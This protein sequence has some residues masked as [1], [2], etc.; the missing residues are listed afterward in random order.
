MTS[1]KYFHS[2]MPGAP[3]MSGIAGAMVAVLDACLVNGFGAGN[4]DSLTVTDGVATAIRSAGHPFSP[5][6]IVL[7]SGA[8]PAGLNGQFRVLTTTTTTY[9][10]AVTGV[11]NGPASGTIT[12]K[13][14]PAGWEKTYSTTNKAVYR[15]TNVEGTRC[16]LR[17]DDTVTLMS[18]V[19]GYSSMTDV[20]TGAGIFPSSSQMSGGA[21]WPKSNSS[22]SSS[23]VW[24]VI[25]DDRSFFIHVGF[26]GWSSYQGTCFFG[27]FTS[28]KQT[29]PYAC[30]LH[31]Y[32]SSG[33]VGN[34]DSTGD[35]GYSGGGNTWAPRGV[36]GL[37]GSQSLRRVAAIPLLSAMS[38]NSGDASNAHPAFPNPADNGLYL[39]EMLVGETSPVAS[40]RG[41]LPGL[42]YCFNGVG[43][44]VFPLHSK[45]TGVVG[46]PGRTLLTVPNYNGV[47]FFDITGPWR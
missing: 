1:V 30:A 37:G 20:D 27:D 10:F 26:G 12:H 46:M 28:K 6:Q 3:T 45:V 11:S 32:S 31:G 13:V 40:L 2:S 21:Y 36:S 18:R 34:S 9:T 24:T 7:I 22:D 38:A 41:T 23:R 17:V 47:N 44:A 43:N 8:T 4:L 39:T 33:V 14:A 29:D 5:D 42:R 15:S 19:V 25:A 16:Y 35:V